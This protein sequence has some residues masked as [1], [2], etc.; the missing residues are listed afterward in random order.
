MPDK[1]EKV[2]GD[3]TYGIVKRTA[4]DGKMWWVLLERYHWHDYIAPNTYYLGKY[5]TL[6]DAKYAME[7]CDKETAMLRGVWAW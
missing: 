6:K 7:K 1:R 5:K 4:L 2:V 3:S